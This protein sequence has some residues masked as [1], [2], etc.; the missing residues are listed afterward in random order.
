MDDLQS[1]MSAIMND[2]EMMQKIMAM[3]QSLGQSPPPEPPP[4]KKPT[5]RPESENAFPD[6]DL[7]TIQRISG[8]A[9]QS[10]IDH[11]QKALLN[12]LAPYLSKDRV[13]KLE[14]AMRAAKLAR[15]ASSFIG[16]SGA[17][18]GIGR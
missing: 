11:N 18:F 16:Q 4:P 5:P 15:L 9:R 3:A 17:M 10:G 13:N 8:F 12:A 1:Q 6:L 2:P 7:N 14:K